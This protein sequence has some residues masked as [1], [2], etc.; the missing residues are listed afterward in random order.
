MHELPK[1][2]QI[3]Y[4]KEVQCTSR[5]HKQLNETRKTTHEQKE[6]ITDDQK[7][8]KKEPNGN[9]GTE[10]YNNYFKNSLE[11]INIRLD[12]AERKIS[13]LEDNSFGITMSEEQKGRMQK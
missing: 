12:Q 9:L 13:K 7:N 2:L 11:E 1:N 4:P 6:S 10:E 5:E 8:W 3:N